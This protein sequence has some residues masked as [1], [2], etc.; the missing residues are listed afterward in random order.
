MHCLM[1]MSEKHWTE[2][3]IEAIRPLIENPP[4]PL[5][6]GAHWIYGRYYPD[7]DIKSKEMELIY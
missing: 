3:Q 5:E 1:I 4:I 2:A 6:Q 7:I